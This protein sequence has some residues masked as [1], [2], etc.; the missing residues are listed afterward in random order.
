VPM[1]YPVPQP[2]DM[3]GVPLTVCALILTALPLLWILAIVTN[4]PRE[5][6]IIL[7]FGALFCWIPALIVAIVLIVMAARIWQRVVGIICVAIVVIGTP[8]VA[9]LN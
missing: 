1:V 3:R 7:L 6:G 4:P 2:G 8:V 9:L 5:F